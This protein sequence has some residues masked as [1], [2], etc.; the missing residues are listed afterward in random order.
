M[1]KVTLGK[2]PPKDPPKERVEFFIANV[3]KYMRLRHK[4]AKE[5]ASAAGLEERPFVNRQNGKTPYLLREMMEIMDY[6]KFSPADRA[7][8]A[9]IEIKIYGML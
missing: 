3:D 5:V 7:E 9:G 8:V 4:T 6:L 2:D 1:P